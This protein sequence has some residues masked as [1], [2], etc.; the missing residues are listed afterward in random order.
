[1]IAVHRPILSLGILP[2]FLLSF[3]PLAHAQRTVVTTQSPGGAVVIQQSGGLPP[4][5]VVV[6][7]GAPGQPPGGPPPGGQPPAIGPDGKPIPP[8]GPNAPGGKGPEGKGPSASSEPIKRTSTPPEPPNK[9]EFE[10]RPDE[11]GMVQFQFR[12]QAWPDLLRWLA[13]TSNLSLDWQ[14]LPSDYLNIATQRKQSLEETRDQFNRHLL[15]RGFTMLEL[16]GMIQVVKTAGINVSLVP[17]VPP[18][19]LESLPPNR[20]VRT[21]FS[22]TTLIAKEAAL[23]F[24]P[25]VSA[26]G[27]LN[28]LDS[29]N[30]LEAMDSAGNLFEIYRILQEEQS[31]EAQESLAREFELEFVRANDARE[32]IISFLGL[33]NKVNRASSGRPTPQELMMQQQEMQMRMQMQQQQQQQGGK[34]PAAAANNEIYVVANVRRNSVIAHAPPDKM[35]VIAAFLRRIDVPNEN[36]AS[37]QSIETRM[38]VYRLMSLDPKQFVASIMAMDALEPTTKLE[39]DEKNRAIIAYASLSDQMIIQQTLDRLDGSARDFEVIQL[40]RL[41]AEDVAGTI[42]FLMGKEEPKQDDRNRRMFYDPFGFSR[43]QEPTNDD[44]FRCGANSQDNQLLLWANEVEIQEV[45][46]LLV[47]LGEIPP[48]GLQRSRV[49]TIDAS[50]SAETKEYLKRLQEAW[51]KV[52]PN[53]LVL[54][55]ETEFE[56][57]DALNTPPEKPAEPA[58]SDASQSKTD[59]QSESKADKNA[60]DAG[61]TDGAGKPQTEEK[62]AKKPDADITQKQRSA[63]ESIPGG[64]LSVHQVSG[65]ETPPGNG[66]SARDAGPAE[67][68]TASS[69]PSESSSLPA[70]SIRLQFDERGNLVLTGDDLDAL[71]RLEQMMLANAPPLKRYEVFYI[72]NAR[73]SWVELNLKDYFKDEEPEKDSN[74]FA[75][76]FGFDSGPKSKSEDP[77]LGKKRQLRFISDIDTRSIIVIGAD[78]QQ[79]K[80]IRS[81]IKLWDVPEKTNR[82]KLRFTRLVRIEHSRADSIVE[83]IKD[84]YR[85]LLSTNDKAFSKGAAGG[86]KESKHEESTETVSDSGGLNFSFTGRLSMGIDRITN[87]VVVSAEGED[88]LKLVIEMIKE[89]DQAAQPS[90]AVQ[91]IELGGTNSEAMERALK[92]L[93]GPKDV[94]RAPQ[95][96][97]ME[98]QQQP[99]VPNQFQ[100]P[101]SQGNAKGRNRRNG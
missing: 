35:A 93:I 6:P 25:L 27:A 62:P 75:F 16:D 40:R 44:S 8:G 34:T 36:S 89:L 84:A 100:P 92:A 66:A 49:R 52:S 48:Q 77:Q 96:P 91:M 53:P 23:E 41:R 68:T 98:G 72:Q 32:Q 46:K 38:K 95:Q 69:L 24:K 19:A 57:K 51:S 21:S 74:P 78:E 30:R 97:G 42:K 79:L 76:I 15:A 45:N 80:T 5:A 4:G 54:P 22:L 61:K 101:E 50:R 10:V 94:Q 26:N 83:A 31:D 73:P 12:N 14:E 47:K 58:S 67:V 64:R 90:G 7:E 28:P 86:N 33:E 43:P 70:N 3:P 18:E 71:D 1:M 82:Q 2:L 9:K 85:D 55:D 63:A 99:N 39:V 13:E 59:A 20:F 56:K 37:L 29:T 11:R 17:K 88:L 60:D 81:L 65:G 87:S